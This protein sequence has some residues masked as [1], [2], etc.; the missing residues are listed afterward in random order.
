MA[1]KSAEG[2]WQIFRDTIS[3]LVKRH[4]PLRRRR[5]QSRPAWM[6]REILK[7]IR[8]KKRLWKKVRY[9]NVTDEDRGVEREV[10][11]E[12]DKEN[13]KE[14]KNKAGGGERWQQMPL[15]RLHEAEDENQADNRPTERY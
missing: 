7:A 4:V 13:K 2:A 12:H 8:Q 14:V 9:G 3:N 6:S 11:E 10:K 1:S 15:H 5:K